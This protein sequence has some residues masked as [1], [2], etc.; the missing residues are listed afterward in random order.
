MDNIQP[1]RENAPQMV[2]AMFDA[3]GDNRLD[4]AETWLEKLRELNQL[5]P[6]HPDILAF[7]S[8]I[9]IQ[10]GQAMDAL[11]QI[12][13]LPEDHAPDVKLMCL[14]YAEDPTWQGLAAELAESSPDP[15]VRA[16]MSSMLET[17]AART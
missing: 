3:I 10:R 5:A 6:D 1:T 13:S 7:S 2:E 17:A 12:N 9:T 11:R 8:I 15:R 16:T 4:D 14:F